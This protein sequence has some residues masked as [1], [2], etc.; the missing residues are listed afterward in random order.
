MQQDVHICFDHSGLLFIILFSS[1]LKRSGLLK[2][3]YV[4]TSEQAVSRSRSKSLARGT[5]N[6]VLLPALLK[7]PLLAV[8]LPS[9]SLVGTHI[10]I[11]ALH[12]KRI[13]GFVSFICP[14]GWFDLAVSTGRKSAKVHRGGTRH[15]PMNEA[16]DVDECP[17]LGDWS[18]RTFSCT[19]HNYP[20][21]DVQ[22]LGHPVHD[23]CFDL[24]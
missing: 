5:N 24:A 19:M 9:P 17:Q 11:G 8:I 18:F 20:R 1:S 7:I 13:H 2:I 16:S 22:L 4:V 21:V 12:W 23:V 3:P 10:P 14:K 15:F 6:G